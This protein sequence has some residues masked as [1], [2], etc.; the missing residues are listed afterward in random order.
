MMANGAGSEPEAM[1]LQQIQLGHSFESY[2][3]LTEF[4]TGSV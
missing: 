4:I 3:W 2:E 1:I